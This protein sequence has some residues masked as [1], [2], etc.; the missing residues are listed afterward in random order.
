MSR[1]A[2]LLAVVFLLLVPLLPAGPAAA[3]P[4]GRLADQ[5]TDRVGALGGDAGGVQDALDELRS[6][7][8]TQIFVVFVSG[9]DGLG[10]QEWADRTAV[11][12]Q[13]GGDDLLFAVAVDDRAY[14]LSVDDT[15]PGDEAVIDDVLR[16]EVEPRLSA[17]DWGG[18]VVALA[19]GLR[20]NTGSNT[21]SDAGSGGDGGGAAL[22]AVAGVA[23]VGGG[24]YLLVRSRR[25]RKSADAEATAAARAADP[26]PDETTE[27]LTYRASAALLDVDEAARTSQL[28][29]DFA[30]VQYGEEP[31]AGFAEALAQSQAELAS[32]FTLRQQLDD[33]VPEDEPSRRGLLAELLRLATSADQRLD[34]Q[35]EAFDR[36]RDLE[37]TAPQVLERLGPQV[38]ALQARVPQE[39]QRLA[40][41]R[42]RYADSALAP[43]TGNPAQATALLA[44]AA[45]EVSEARTDVQ[46]GQ[47]GQAV[48]DLRAAEDAV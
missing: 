9:F 4:P 39:E 13:L 38:T 14:G 12:S 33:E 34:A 16:S 28:D 42:S 15:Y 40:E 17:D 20:A 45:Q 31:V 30:R 19:D 23:V 48:A 27:Q 37:R 26:F 35:A 3:E 47:P 10:G 43:V 25:R 11:T 36:L 29:L 2:R 22:A 24:G 6:E 5:V 46:A 44:V 7:N 1:S 41:L 18:A 8:G 32:A 21:G